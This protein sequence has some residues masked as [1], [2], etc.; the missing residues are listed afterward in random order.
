MIKTSG[1]W[2]VP[3]VF[4]AFQWEKTYNKYRMMEGGTMK[5]A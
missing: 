3:E 1:Q 4:V 2:N 5:N